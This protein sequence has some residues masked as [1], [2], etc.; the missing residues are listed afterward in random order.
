MDRV[1]DA[2]PATARTSTARAS[3]A[4]GGSPRGTRSRVGARSSSRGGRPPEA[5]TH[6]TRH[7][8]PPEL[9]ARAAGAVRALPAAAARSLRG[10]RRP[11]DRGEL[12]C[13]RETAQEPPARAVRALRGRGD[14]ADRSDPSSCGAHSSA[15]AERLSSAWPGGGADRRVRGGRAHRP[16]GMATVFEAYQPALARA[17][18]LSASTCAPTT[19]RWPSGSS[20]SR[21]SRRRSTTRTS[22]RLRL[23]RVRG[24]AVHRDG[25]PPARLAAAVRR[26]ARRVAGVQRDRGLAR[27]PRPRR[28]P[29]IAHRDLKPE[30]VLVT[31]VGAVKIA[32]FGI[33]RRTRPHR[34]L[35]GHRRGRRHAR[36]YAPE[37]ALSKPAVP[38]P[39]ST[40]SASWRTSCSAARRRSRAAARRWRSLPARQRGSP[41]PD[42][43]P[44]PRIAAW[45]SGCSRSGPRRGRPRAAQAWAELEEGDRRHPR[46]YWRRDRSR[47]GRRRVRP[48]HH[49]VEP[50]APTARKPPAPTP[51]QP[52][53]RRR[54][55]R[56]RLP[57][58]PRCSRS[59]APS[60]CWHWTARTARRPSGGDDPA[61]GMAPRASRAVRLRRR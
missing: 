15:G 50:R 11:R 24:G 23:L 57:A 44:T 26:P 29:R 17:V 12:V 19:R 48:C 6:T 52:P 59:A 8:A 4:A 32:D 5:T 40:R 54:R 61:P 56:L 27:W 55:R 21:G 46:P 43:W 60:R 14:A 7:A 10:R 36:L 39:T 25:V 49:D 47:R 45:S 37:Q 42:R 38:S 2:C 18:A 58:P 20:A 16:G 28:A 1:D 51:V 30:N 34:Q 35:H 33:A 41:T 53:R 31:T 22:S 3:V 9:S 13:E